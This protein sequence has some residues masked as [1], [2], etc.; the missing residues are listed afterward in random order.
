MAEASRLGIRYPL[1]R[2]Q[3]QGVLR[4]LETPSNGSDLSQKECLEQIVTCL[5]AGDLFRLAELL[6][7]ARLQ[8]ISHLSENC[9]EV[10]SN[11][12][13][14]DQIIVTRAIERLVNELAFVLKESAGVM[15]RRICTQWT[16][17]GSRR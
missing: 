1:S 13:R 11:S 16:K 15:R 17:K 10:F 2:L 12:Q 6:R 9:A 7:D 5:H 3:A 8:G 4:I 14:R